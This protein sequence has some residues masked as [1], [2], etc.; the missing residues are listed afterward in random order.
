MIR[1]REVRVI[2]AEG[3]QLGI[4]STKE[5]TAMA[6]EAGYDLVEVSSQS[7]PPVCRIMDYGKFLYVQEKKARAAKK[8]HKT[9]SVKEITLRPGTDV[10]D[11]EVKK[12]HLIRFLGE[13]HRAKVVVRFRGRELAHTGHGLDILERLRQDLKGHAVVEYEPAME[14]KRMIMVFA[15]VATKGKKAAK[16]DPQD[17]EA[18][19]A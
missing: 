15:P 19:N 5:A 9:I 10:H 3:K 14:G 1:A 12:K 8:K 18:Q 17:A 6:Q 16:G 13:G 7:I 2:D 11:Y 4:M